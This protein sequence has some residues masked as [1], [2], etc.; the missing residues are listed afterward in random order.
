M[1]SKKIGEVQ[2]PKGGYT[3]LKTM[4]EV[5]VYAKKTMPPD[6]ILIQ[7]A[8]G[9]GLRVDDYFSNIGKICNMLLDLDVKKGQKAGAFLPNCLEYS[10]LYTA[11]GRLGVTFVPI[12]PFLKGDSLSYV[13]NH[14]DIEYLFTNKELFLDKI[15]EIAGSLRNIDSILFL[16]EEVQADEFKK[17]A[18]LSNFRNYPSE[19]RQLWDVRSTDAFVIWLTSGTTGLPKGVVTSQEYMLH[20]T[21]FSAHYFRVGPSDVIYFVLPMYHMPFFV[22]GIA[23]AMVGVCKVVFIDWFSATKFWEHIAKYKATMVYS[24]GTIIPI[25]LKNEVGLF[26]REGKDLLRLW[27]AWPLDQPDIV[28]GRWPK[29]RF[30][31]G[32]GLSEYALATMTSYDRQEKGSQGRATPFTEVR[33]CDPETGEELPPGKMGE[34]VLRGKHG[35]AYMMQGYYNSREDTERVIRNGWLY[36]GDAGYLDQERQLHFMDRLRDS[37]RVGGENV[38]SVQVETIIRSHPKIMEAAIVGIKGEL[39]HDEIVAHV[40]LREREELS[41]EEFFEFCTQRM[42]YFMV[43]KYLYI[44]KELPKTATFRIQKYKLREEGI[45]QGCF[46]RKT[47][48][49]GRV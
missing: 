30:V 24:T 16:D 33:I 31:E 45:P 6:Q 21:S 42:A 23:L 14:C 1:G 40:V 2:K 11:L 34:I 3:F 36:S 13:I 7:R 32:Y 15:I 35:P 38:P 46:S 41:P 17:T 18:P 26:E 10:Y 9:D 19:F 48:P 47:S 44:R 39:G 12:N 43:P 20:R 4:E 27:S 22:W 8:D 28:Y 29:T 37:I 49:K 5:I 25:L